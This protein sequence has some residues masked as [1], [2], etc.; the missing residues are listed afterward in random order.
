MSHRRLRSSGQKHC[1][2]FAIQFLWN[3]KTLIEIVFKNPPWSA[4][5]KNS[6]EWISERDFKKK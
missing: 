2:L 1:G 6:C 4:K 5:D 3:E